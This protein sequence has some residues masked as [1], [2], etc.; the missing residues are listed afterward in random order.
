MK[1]K[2]IKISD[3]LDEQI[4]K[5][6]A[7]KKVNKSQAIR[8]LI[9]AG[10]DVT[11][12]ESELLKE[13][14]SLRAD[15]RDSHNFN[16]KGF[17][18]LASLSVKNGIKIFSIWH[19]ILIQIFLRSKDKGLDDNLCVQSKEEFTRTAKSY[20]INEYKNSKEEN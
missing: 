12:N 10:I 4:M 19:G 16:K 9:V 8:E 20:G 7:L 11:A 17:D 13:I 14:K 2:V 1:T 5:Y 6:T 3:D 15:V 18:R